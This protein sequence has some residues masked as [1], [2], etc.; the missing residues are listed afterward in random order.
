MIYV[1]WGSLFIKSEFHT[2]LGRIYIV[3]TEKAV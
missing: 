1:N 2:N 3:E